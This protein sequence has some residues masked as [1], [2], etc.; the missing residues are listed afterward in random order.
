MASKTAQVIYDEIVAHIKEEG[1]GASNWYAGIT[2]DI[3]N[4]LFGDHNVPR[5][6]HWRIHRKASSADAARKVEKALLKYGCDGGSG[7]GDDDAIYVYAY[8]KT[9]V[10][11]P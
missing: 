8:K 9:H 11:N 7:G 2:E 6:D 3:D 10:T 4:R 1:N 5:K